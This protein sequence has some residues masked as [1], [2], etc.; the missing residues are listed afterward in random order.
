MS[1]G[2]KLPLTQLSNLF[3]EHIQ[4]NTSPHQRLIQ[5]IYTI[6]N[7]RNFRRQLQHLRRMRVCRQSEKI[8][9]GT[10]TIDFLALLILFA[11]VARVNARQPF[12]QFLNHPI[13]LLSI[14]FQHCF[15]LFPFFQQPLNRLFSSLQQLLIFQL[16]FHL[17]PILRKQRLNFELRFGSRHNTHFRH[18]LLVFLTK[19][20]LLRFDPSFLLGSTTG[21]FGGQ[22]GFGDFLFDG[23]AS[24][25][26]FLRF[27]LSIILLVHCRC[28]CRTRAIGSAVGSAVRGMLRRRRRRLRIRRRI[29]TAASGPDARRRTRR[30]RPLGVTRRVAAEQAAHPHG[31][32]RQF[33]SPRPPFAQIRQIHPSVQSDVTMILLDRHG[34]DGSHEDGG[35]TE[36]IGRGEVDVDGYVVGLAAVGHGEGAAEHEDGRCGSSVVEDEGFGRG[37]EVST[38]GG[39]EEVFGVADDALG[40]AV[41]ARE[42]MEEGGEEINRCHGD[43]TFWERIVLKKFDH[44]DSD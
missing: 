23:L 15:L 17:L 27:A 43:D 13:H 28:G 34:R 37:A 8:N 7:C 40:V 9:F 32:L 33:V 11:F 38:E 25:S 1:L 10:V 39:A 18:G 41:G 21:R 24:S 5:I 42:V 35:R 20:S 31:Q 44:H 14:L 30:G 26:F 16:H 22:I 3:H 19:T 6:V 2:Q 4:R 36:R 12:F 29:P